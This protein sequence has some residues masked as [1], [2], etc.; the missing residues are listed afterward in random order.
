M[1]RKGANSL[2]VLDGF[3]FNMGHWNEAVAEG[4]SF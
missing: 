4:N 3:Y 1:S 2:K